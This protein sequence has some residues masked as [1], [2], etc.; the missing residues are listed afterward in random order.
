MR[1]HLIIPV[2]AL[3]ALAACSSSKSVSSGVTIDSSVATSDTTPASDDSTTST[4][5]AST[6]TTAE[7]TTTV[8]A[9]EPLV[10]RSD[11]IGPFRLGDLGEEVANGLIARLGAS[12]S[13][14][15]VEYPVADGIGRYT[16]VDGEMGFV[17]PLGRSVCWA[18]GLCAEFG[19]VTVV[20]T[21]FTG[22]TYRDDD[23]GSLL[24]S[25]G[26]T[27][28]TRWSDAPAINAEPGGCY[29][30]G[31]GDVDGIRLTLSSDGVPFSSFDD[32]GNYVA[33]LP[34]PAQV[35]VIWMETGENPQF[36][37]GDC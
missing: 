12:A 23:T 25:S 19:G 33:N 11:G 18:N 22:W 36:L 17:A 32:L 28:G 14:V 20:S 35:T 27:V 4:A 31:G 21:S 5:V 2:I 8:P 15:M 6:T 10:L 26:V 7:T 16:T 3:L 1:R 30:V 9:L 29:S 37:Y 13:D 34:P 24:S